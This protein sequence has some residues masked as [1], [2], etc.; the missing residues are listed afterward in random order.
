[1]TSATDCDG[2]LPGGKN[3][4]S[5]TDCRIFATIGL[6]GSASTWVFNVARELMTA[7]YGADQL[8]SLYADELAQLPSSDSLGSKRLLVK[9]HHG[10]AGMDDWL[11]E[12][13][14][15][16]IL[17]VRDPRDAC[18][19]MSQRFKAPL[20]HTVRWIAADCQRMARLI[21]EGHLLLRYEDRYFEEPG[22]ISRIADVLGVVV[23]APEIASIFDLYR[24]DAVRRFAER[25]EEL[26]PE[27]R[28]RVGEWPMD[29][30]TQILGPHIGDGRTGKW[31]DL[32]Q[33]LPSE[34]TAFFAPFLGPLGYCA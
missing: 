16:L 24:T 5:R 14:T 29:K 8:V 1:M 32:S 7:A 22:S 27:R 23:E 9:S 10:S 15:P 31:R 4:D 11:T 12:E 6:H 34:L 21:G 28:Q 20:R 13:R 3:V 30:L 26:P 19:S 17:S 2:V 25:L 18:L 33:P